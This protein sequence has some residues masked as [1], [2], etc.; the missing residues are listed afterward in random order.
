LPPTH[1][2][3]ALQVT[4]QAP[5]FAFAVFRSAHT[6]A[7]SVVPGEHAQLAFM[8]T[9][10]PAQF[11]PQKPQLCLSLVRSTHE[12]P[13]RASPVEHAGPHAPPLHTSA[14]RQRVPQAPQLFASDERST[15]ALPPRPIPMHSVSPAE[16]EQEPPMQG[17]PVGHAFPQ[18]PQFAFDVWTLTH[19]APP[20][21]P[22]P[23][24]MVSPVEQPMTHAP[25]EH[26]EPPGHRLPQPP[27][28]RG[29]VC[30]SVH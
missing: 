15:H 23:S 2:W 14:P 28:L 12:D 8:H 25:A 29:S 26:I 1:V 13:H 11:C 16:H 17:A 20:P 9:R 5:Q 7:Q 24:H 21:G 10:A 30:V 18:L 4:P 22:A 6:P 19:A 3:P 27:Q